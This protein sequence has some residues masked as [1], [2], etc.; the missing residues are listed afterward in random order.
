MIVRNSCLVQPHV[1]Y[2]QECEMHR[3]GLGLVYSF[4][5]NIVILFMQS[6][7]ILYMSFLQFGVNTC[8]WLHLPTTDV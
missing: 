3:F 7:L 4:L 8:Y 2:E 1:R 5:E 6:R